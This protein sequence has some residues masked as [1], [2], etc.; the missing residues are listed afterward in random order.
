[1]NEDFVKI[2]KCCAICQHLWNEK[3]CI[4][5]EVYNDATRYGN[6]TFDD[7]VKYKCCCVSFKLRK[8][9]IQNE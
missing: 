1:M 5:Y 9:F 8:D 7:F 3:D 2:N 4:A 6:Q